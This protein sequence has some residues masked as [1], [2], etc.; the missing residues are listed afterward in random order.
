MS[1]HGRVPKWTKGTDCKS[2]IRGFESHLGLSGTPVHHV[3]DAMKRLAPIILACSIAGLSGCQG[4][5]ASIQPDSPIDLQANPPLHTLDQGRCTPLGEPGVKAMVLVFIAPECPIANFYQP[6]LARLDQLASNANMRMFMVYPDATLQAKGVRGH[7]RDF[8]ITTPV[9]LDPHH[10]LVEAVNAQV[11]PEAFIVTNEGDVVY[12]GRIDDR[13]TGLGM[14]R[15]EPGDRSLHDA[16][17]AIAAGRPVANART[18][19]IGC[20]IENRPS[21]TSGGDENT[22]SP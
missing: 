15:A 19:P 5:G 6:E 11:T 18:E 21:P 7:V 13:Y 14:R 3:K 10:R 22:D 2:V 1:K 4:T 20:Y 17:L 12:S 16:I 8:N 9:I